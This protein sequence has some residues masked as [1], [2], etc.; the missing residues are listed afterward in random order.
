LKKAKSVDKITKNH[1]ASIRVGDA[2]DIKMDDNI[3]DV[4]L[5]LGPLYHI[6][7]R[8]DRVKALRESL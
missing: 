8:K 6:T 1:L 5:F 3:A 2:R 4:V 7:D